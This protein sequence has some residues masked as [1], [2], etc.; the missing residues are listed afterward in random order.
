MQ[1]RT[2]SRIMP[3]APVRPGTNDSLERFETE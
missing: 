1:V 3:G 2:A